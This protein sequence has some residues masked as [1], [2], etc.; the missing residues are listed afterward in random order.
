MDKVVHFE[1]PF[2][3]VARAQKFYKG[4][5]GW[6]ITSVP[7]MNYH[8]VHTVEV[9]EKRMPKQAGAINGGMYKRDENS[10][11]SPVIVIDVANVDDY[12]KKI[13]KAGGKV[14]SGKRQVGDM[15]F[16]AQISDT[17]GNV[18]GIWETILKKS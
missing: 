14:V 5:F 1:I 4:V 15:G 3:D 12:I 9:D 18:I 7:E 16:Y 11:K 13:K 10:A 8:M 17:E 2:D 6:N